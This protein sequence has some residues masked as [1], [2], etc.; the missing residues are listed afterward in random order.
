[1]HH[2]ENMQCGPDGTYTPQVDPYATSV[3][4]CSKKACPF[5]PKDI[6]TIRDFL[7][8]NN[9]VNIDP[10]QHKCKR[11]P[12]QILFSNIVSTEPGKHAEPNACPRSGMIE[13]LKN[14]RGKLR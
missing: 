8:S 3:R 1:M 7:F 4:S 14:E 10:V 13:A 6:S 2:E 9:E 11:E 12:M 5:E